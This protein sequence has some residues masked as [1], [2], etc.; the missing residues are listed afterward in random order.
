MS[1]FGTVFDNVF[2]VMSD[3]SPAI[4]T[5]LACAGVVVTAVVAIKAG[6]KIEKIMNEHKEDMDDLEEKFNDEEYAM[7]EETF[8]EYKKEKNE[9]IAN[10][11]KRIVPV[12][13]P[14]VIFTAATIV[15]AIASDKVSAKRIAAV[16]AAYEIASL[17]LKNEREAINE[18]VPKK[19]EEIKEAVIKKKME[20]TPIPDEKYIYSTGRGDILCKDVYTGVCFRSS[21][22]EIA[23]AIN[24]VSKMCMAESWVTVSDLYYELGVKKIPPI[25]TDIGWHD[26]NLVEGSI[27]AHI[28]TCWDD[29]GTVP[30]IGLDYEVDP[31]FKEGGRFRH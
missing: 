16:S 28:I 29:T 4:L 2:K 10:T 24:A 3:H 20:S 18:L 14:V 31:F 12:M 25:A 8:K 22:E 1:K 17:S 9:I 11:A 27:P 26:N 19:A 7:S 23:R 21:H 30:V 5:G 6:P 13:A 15:S